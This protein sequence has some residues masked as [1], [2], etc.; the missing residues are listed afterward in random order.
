M[1]NLKLLILKDTHETLLQGEF[2]KLLISFLYLGPTRME[3]PHFPLGCLVEK[4]VVLF[5]KHLRAIS[6]AK[7]TTLTS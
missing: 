7:P 3:V 5:Q 6:R 2:L 1:K 4:E